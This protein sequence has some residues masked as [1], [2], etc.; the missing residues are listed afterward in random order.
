MRN[1]HRKAIAVGVIVWSI[2]LFSL[3]WGAESV[4]LVLKNGIVIN[5]TGADP[6]SN[7]VVVMQQDRIVAVGAADTFT[8]PA[9]AQVIDVNGATILPGF[10]NAHVHQGYSAP[11]LKAWAQGGVTTVRDLGAH[12]MDG[13]WFTRRDALKRDPQNARLVAAGPFITVPG[14]YPIVPWGGNGITITSPEEAAQKTEG[15]LQQGADVIK[16]T[17]E[18]GGIFGQAIPA[19]SIEEV[20]AMVK[21]AHTHGTLVS[22]HILHSADI[23]PLLAAGVDDIVHMVANHLSDDVITKVIAQGTYWVPTLELWHGVGH[24]FGPVAINNLRRFVQAGGANKIA[25]GTDYAGYSSPFDLGMPIREILWMQAAGLTPMQIIVAATKQA[26]HVCNLEKELGTLEPGKI[27]DILV[28]N[29]N[30]LDNLQALLDVKL[31]IHNGVIAR[32]AD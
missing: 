16:T 32:T 28:V 14:G 8:I 12:T 23:E 10:I 31:V 15:L 7:A 20:A 11:N 22:A 21:V 29:G 18:T 5:G 2:L 4:T 1:T 24:G 3:A 30:P 26:A 9:D 13:Q 19:P 17:L 25:L 6:V 27:A